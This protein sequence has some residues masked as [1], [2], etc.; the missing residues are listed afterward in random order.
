[1][2]DV[3]V[4]LRDVE[5]WARETIKF[6][7]KKMVMSDRESNLYETYWKPSANRYSHELVVGPDVEE[8]KWHIL[9]V[10]RSF[11]PRCIL[12]DF[13]VY[14]FHAC[15]AAIDARGSLQLCELLLDYLTEYIIQGKPADVPVVALEWG[16]EV[17]RLPPAAALAAVK[18]AGLHESKLMEIPAA[19]AQHLSQP[20]S[21]SYFLLL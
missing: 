8:R 7:E 14:R 10:F 5:E 17:V 11:F 12:I 16:K 18:A 9:S 2:Y 13:W 20:V 21:Q 3:P 1:M 19:P 4:N 15:H 6:T